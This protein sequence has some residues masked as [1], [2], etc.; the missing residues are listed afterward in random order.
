MTPRR[1]GR[2]SGIVTILA[3]AL[4][5]TI[6]TLGLPLPGVVSP[7][8]H[9]TTQSFTLSVDDAEF[10]AL[11]PRAPDTL[12][13]TF[14]NNTGSVLTLQQVWLVDASTGVTRT[15]SLPS[16]REISSGTQVRTISAWNVYGFF[17]PKFYGEEPDTTYH[18]MARA[19]TTD[20]IVHE[21][22]DTAVLHWV[23]APLQPLDFQ[24][25]G[26]TTVPEGGGNVTL[27]LWGEGRAGFAFHTPEPTWL[28]GVTSP[29]LGD[30][31]AADNP[32]I[33]STTC[34][35]GRRTEPFNT[36]GFICEVVLP[37]TATGSYT[38]T[39]SITDGE[40]TQTGTF[41]SKVVTVLDAQPSLAM[42]VTPTPATVK[43]PVGVIRYDVALTNT[44]DSHDPI[45]L[46]A[47]SDPLWGNV[48]QPN[49]HVKDTTCS[50]GEV[51]EPGVTRTCSFT[52]TIKGKAGKVVP[53]N[54]TAV[55]HDD[56]GNEVTG[57]A[58]TSVL[59]TF[60]KY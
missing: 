3:I 28:T 22:G 8:A 54:L 55:A 26:P 25:L 51:I 35:S 36:S 4:L 47:L 32:K 34:V 31:F 46:T 24:I 12:T 17:G 15:L 6:T 18:V 41:T 5:S 39:I 11:E 23:D 42:T 45:T 2:P 21:T 19:T 30:I 53:T 13:L 59:F 20:G 1:A 48:L 57:T 7:Q 38:F 52:G 60:K 43:P 27:T 9:A 33:A 58:S 37:V 44:S 49:L 50:A 14:T 40:T 10:Q 16:Q 56:E 29:E